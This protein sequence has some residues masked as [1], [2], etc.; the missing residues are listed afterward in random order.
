[1]S[2]DGPILDAFTAFGRSTE[3]PEW[4]F[5]QMERYVCILYKPSG[6]VE[7]VRELRWSLF[8]QNGKEGRQLPPTLGTLKPH[9]ERAFFMALVWKSSCKPCPNIPPPTHYSWQLQD[10]NLIPVLSENPPAPKALL[11]L[12]R[13]SCSSSCMTNRFGCRKNTLVCTDACGCSDGC[14]NSE[15]YIAEIE[16]EEELF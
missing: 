12:R 9:T 11:E 1:M 16:E 10:G 5:K 8:A 7:S 6:S 3:V 2:S 13:C 15:D 4:V 14:E